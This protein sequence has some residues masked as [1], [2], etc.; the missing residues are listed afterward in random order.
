MSSI[1]DPFFRKMYKRLAEEL[2]GRRSVL[3]GGS[4]LSIG[5]DG[6]IDAVATALKYKGDVSYI[7][8]LQ[9]VINLGL[10]LD[11]EQYGARPQND[12]LG[13]D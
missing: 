2:D 10:E 13:D 5:E 1:I 9:A 6:R 7:E 12:D 4:A 8:C 11:R 3:A